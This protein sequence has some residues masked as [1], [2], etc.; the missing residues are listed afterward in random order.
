MTGTGTVVKPARRM[1]RAPPAARA[2]A[3]SAPRVPDRSSGVLTRPRPH[4]GDLLSKHATGKCLLVQTSEQRAMVRRHVT[5]RQ[6]LLRDLTASNGFSK[7]QPRSSHCARCLRGSTS[8]SVAQPA[9]TPPPRRLQLAWHAEQLAAVLHES[10]GSES[11]TPSQTPGQ[12]DSATVAAERH[13][14][15]APTPAGR[16]AGEGGV[17]DEFTALFVCPVSRMLLPSHAHQTHG[18]VTLAVRT[19]RPLHA[20]PGLCCPHRG[21]ILPSHLTAMPH[22]PS[23]P[24]ISLAPHADPMLAKVMGSAGSTASGPTT[25]APR[26]TGLRPVAEILVFQVKFHFPLL[27]PFTQITRALSNRTRSPLLPQSL[28]GMLRTSGPTATDTMPPAAVSRTRT[29]PLAPP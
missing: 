20:I 10:S 4:L 24:A 23:H 7:Q 18:A 29:P 12:P 2:S 1:A 21:L 17:D 15:A 19:P 22:L 5:L 13:A 8:P 28:Y 3:P 26:P 16:S 9:L 14:W 6:A 11:S 25:H 27:S